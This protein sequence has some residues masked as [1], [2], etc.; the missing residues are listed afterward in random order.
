MRKLVAL[1]PLMSIISCSP[2][3]SVNPETG[4]LSGKRVYENYCVSCH[5]LQGQIKVKSNVTLQESKVNDSVMRHRI[6]YGSKEGMPSYQSLLTK[7]EINVLI[8]HIKT[9]IRN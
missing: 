8:D 4:E 3:S 9:A 2:P 5:G 6:L 1:I 7:E